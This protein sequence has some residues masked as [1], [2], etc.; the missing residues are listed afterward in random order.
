MIN[1]FSRFRDVLILWLFMG[2][3]IVFSQTGCLQQRKALFG[4]SVTCTV[5]V[6]QTSRQVELKKI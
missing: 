3:T 4:P 2:M 5:K 1:I 6:K